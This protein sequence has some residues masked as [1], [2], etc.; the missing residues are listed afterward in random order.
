MSK[1]ERYRERL[2]ECLCELSQNKTINHTLNAHSL[3]QTLKLWQMND[4]I[5]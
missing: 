3:T 1:K 2:K 5:D 4:Y